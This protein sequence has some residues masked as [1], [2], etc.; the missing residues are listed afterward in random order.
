MPDSCNDEGQESEVYF[1]AEQAIA[2]ENRYQEMILQS[3]EV[4]QRI[5][6]WRKALSICADLSFCA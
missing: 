6:L 2:L 3:S 5:Q 4:D 1:I